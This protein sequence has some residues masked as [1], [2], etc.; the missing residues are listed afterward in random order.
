MRKLAFFLN[1]LQQKIKIKII[2]K[3]LCNFKVPYK[4]H[5]GC[6]S[7]RLDDWINIDIDKNN[8]I[9]DVVWDASCG[10]PFLENNSCFLIYNE[11][12]LEHLS[13]EQAGIF[14]KECYRVLEFNGILRIA[15]PSLEYTVN[16]YQSENWRDQDWLTWKGNEF[17]QT[18]AE[19]INIAFRWWGHQW[20]YDRE[21]LHRRLKEAGF[22]IIR[23]VEWGYS[24]IPELSN[25][26][27]RKDS[28]LICEA[29]KN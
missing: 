17:I 18:R 16:K 11:H 15:M 21:E 5:I 20:L 9:V 1:R 7:I 14:L 25:L 13:I 3:N 24:K 27:T 26:E 6:G 4:L 22:T 28:K 29:T 12:F 19:M 8:P 2:Q 23:D 10:L